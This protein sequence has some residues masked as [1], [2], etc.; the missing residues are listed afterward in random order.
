MTAR[1]FT[2]PDV[3][4]RTFLEALAIGSGALA[5]GACDGSVEPAIERDA[6]TPPIDRDGSPENRAP[7]W[8]TIPAIAFTQGVASSFSIAEYVS[9]DDGDALAITLDDRALPVGV[10]FDAENLRFDYDGSGPVASSD[11][12]VLTADDGR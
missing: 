5:L 7:R 3:P 1:T 8:R 9:D 12:H 6:G 2:P 11:G 10:T 4:R